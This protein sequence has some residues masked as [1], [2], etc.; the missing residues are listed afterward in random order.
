MSEYSTPVQF[1]ILVGGIFA[2]YLAY[3]LCQEDITTKW[4]LEHIHLGWF[5][6]SVQCLIYSLFSWVGRSNFAGSAESH[7]HH[8][9]AQDAI[10]TRAPFRSFLLIGFLSFLTIGFSNTA[11]E[12]ISYNTHLAFKSSKPVSVM[13]M[14]VIILRKRYRIAEYLATFAITFGLMMFALGDYHGVEKETFDVYG[15]FIICFALVIDGMIG[16]VQ[17]KTFAD[18]RVEASEMVMMK[19]L[20]AGGLALLVCATLTDQ[21]WVAMEYYGSHPL[22]YTLTVLLYSFLGCLGE[23]FVMSMIARFGALATVTTTSVRKAITMCLS[24]FMFQRAVTR[25]YALGGILVWC[26]VA[27][28]IYI[29]H[30]NKMTKKRKSEE[31]GGGIKEGDV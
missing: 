12:Y 2:C 3:G 11:V 21:L 19:N 16:N 30:E 27:A 13:L 31:A 9:Q 24:F 20:V 23:T 29:D 7:R 1:I 10:R 6:T 15:V 14:G 26:G 18:Y 8:H 25:E 17:Q 22:S 28:H 4:K 5:L